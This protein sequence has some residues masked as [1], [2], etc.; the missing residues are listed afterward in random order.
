[1]KRAFWSVVLGVSCLGIAVAADDPPAVKKTEDKKPTTPQ[2]I[3][4]GKY[5][6]AGK[7]SGEIEK[8]TEAG[9]KL[10]VLTSVPGKAK[11]KVTQH[12]FIFHDNGLVRW[13]KL[14]S[15]LD[16]KN[17]KIPW[18]QKE[19][20][21]FK[22]PPGAPKYAADRKALETGHIVEVTYARLKDLK[23]ADAVTSDFRV[24]YAV[25]LSDPP[26]ALKKDKDDKKKPEDKKPEKK[27]EEK[28]PPE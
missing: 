1:M 21:D 20:A 25:I 22:Q 10:K 8:V 6:D 5:V 15:N 27:A 19:L 14:P 12:D 18:S 13:D 16:D 17:K 7:I 4:W 28:K 2:K 24:K 11:A 26:A 9:F 23:P 3:D